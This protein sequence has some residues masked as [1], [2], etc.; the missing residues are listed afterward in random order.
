MGALA[1]PGPWIKTCPEDCNGEELHNE[2]VSPEF[3]AAAAVEAG[4]SPDR[5]FYCKIIEIII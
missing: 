3:R 5:R 4:L 1:G 2:R